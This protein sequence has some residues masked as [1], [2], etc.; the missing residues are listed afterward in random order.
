LN[1]QYETFIHI[2][3]KHLIDYIEIFNPYLIAKSFY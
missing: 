1:Q 2:L 3:K